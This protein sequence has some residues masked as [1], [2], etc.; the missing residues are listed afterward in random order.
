MCIRDSSIA[1]ADTVAATILRW[2]KQDNY[3]QTRSA[4][5]YTVTDEDGRWVPTPPAYA[6]AMEPH[7][8]EIRPLVM[9]SASQFVPPP[10]FKYD[11][12]DS[13]CLLYTSD[14]ADERSSVD[15]GG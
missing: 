1:Y 8:N 3:A 10:P 9:D 12:K 5:R 15:L 4:E 6:S 7:W 2:S 11:V 14:A 13:T